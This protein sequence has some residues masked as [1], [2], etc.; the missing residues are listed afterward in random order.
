LV[1]LLAGWII[2]NKE[3][4]LFVFLSGEVF[5]AA[6]GFMGKE[7]KEKEQKKAAAWL[8]QAWA[9]WIKPMGISL[10][11]VLFFTTYV[12]QATQVPS[13]S[14]KPTILAGDHFFLDKLAF[15][16]NYPA[17]LRPYLPD[18]EIRRGKIIAFKTQEKNSPIPFLIKRVIGLPGEILEIRDKTVWIDGRLMDEPYVHFTDPTI[19]HKVSGLPETYWRRDNFGP[20]AIPPNCYFMMGDNR[21]G[22]YDSRFWGTVPKQDIIGRPFLNL[23]YW[24][25]EIEPL[26]VPPQTLGENLRDYANV[27]LHFFEKTRWRRTGTILH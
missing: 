9:E 2:L 6:G 12:A 20:F 24:S 3:T 4:T 14:M 13:E 25:F 8:S 22:S 18:R 11:F 21:D 16:G 27:A 1:F 15:P 23:V 19:F 5:L 10:C 17:F 26:A 7:R